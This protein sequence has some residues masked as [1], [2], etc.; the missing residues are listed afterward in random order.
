[1]F[2]DIF[3]LLSL[4]SQFNEDLLQFLVDIVDAELYTRGQKRCVAPTQY[5]LS[6]CLLET[7]VLENLKPAKSREI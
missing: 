4:E 5:D 1:M 7:V 2:P 6:T 3:L